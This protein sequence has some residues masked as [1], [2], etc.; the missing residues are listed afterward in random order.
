MCMII[1]SQIDVTIAKIDIIP[2]DEIK[3]EKNFRFNH[4]FYSSI[5]EK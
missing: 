5:K 4:F 3:N 2:L 1:Y